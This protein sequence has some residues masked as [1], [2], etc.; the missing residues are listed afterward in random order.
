MIKMNL[1]EGEREIKKTKE[2]KNKKQSGAREWKIKLWLRFDFK[3]W[4]AL[5]QSDLFIIFLASNE[6]CFGLEI[7]C[8]PF[9]YQ[10]HLFSFDH[11]LFSPF[12]KRAKLYEFSDGCSKFKVVLMVSV[13]WPLRASF[14]PIRY[15]ETVLFLCTIL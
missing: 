15:N 1:Q 4:L 13:A 3:V 14:T 12:C 10:Q 5:N 6:Y 8:V 9:A 2:R 7:C 11:F